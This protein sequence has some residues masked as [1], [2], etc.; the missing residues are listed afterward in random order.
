[1]R[2]LAL[3]LVLAACDPE[4]GDVPAS[5]IFIGDKVTTLCTAEED[6]SGATVVPY[7]AGGAF[8]ILV[9]VDAEHFKSTT[10][11]TADI[12]TSEIIAGATLSASV[13]LDEDGT[14]LVGRLPLSWPRGGAFDYTVGVAGESHA[15]S[16]TIEEPVLEQ[17]PVSSSN[18]GVKT[19]VD[20]CLD[21]TTTDGSVALRLDGGAFKDGTAQAT[22]A[23]EPG[24]CDGT[25]GDAANPSS[26]ASFTVTT[27]QT[28]V[29]VSATI[30]GS[31][32]D[33]QAF[34]L[35][36]DTFAP[37]TIDLACPPTAAALSLVELQV[38]AKRGTA[39]ANVEV[40]L[41]TTPAVELVPATAST[42]DDGIATVTFQK[43][44]GS[45][46]VRAHVGTA[47]DDCTI[48]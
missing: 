15:R 2:A 40:T 31:G 14:F 19:S 27:K 11:A 39:N 4:L 42:G 43:P 24:P 26:H 10:R 18:D 29:G 17:G 1:M 3:L 21:S 23:L 35:P 37:V 47:V 20:A 7:R 28:S 5:K 13:A 34:E 25:D 46:Y 32:R 8:E 16:A 6:V 9:C 45:V 30:V 48:D 36:A 12:Q 41:D 38:T 33:P 22:V 44:A